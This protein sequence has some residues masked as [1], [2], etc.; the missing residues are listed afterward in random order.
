MALVTPTY[1]KESSPNAGFKRII[2]KVPATTDNG[3]TF[4]MTLAQYGIS[5]LLGIHGWVHTT[6]GSVVAIESPTT[7]VTSGV[8]TVTV[9]GSEVSDKL[10]VYEILGE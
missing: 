2:V 6:T 1:L 5:T 8:L 7:S 10:R 3:D 4:T 9:G